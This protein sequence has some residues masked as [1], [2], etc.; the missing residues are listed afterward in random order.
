MSVS[1]TG[2][3]RMS[4]T[5]L[6]EAIRSKQVSSQ[7]VIGAHLRRIEEVNPS[8]NA[9]TVVL[10]EQ[11]LEA[12]KAADRAVAGGGDLPPLHGVPFTVKEDIDL[13]GT[14]TTFGAKALRAAFEV[15][16]E[17]SWRDPWT[18]PA[19]LRGPEPAKPIRVAVATD[20]A[21]QGTADQVREGV[22]QAARALDD[23]GYA[24]DEVEPPSIAEAA[25]T[26]VDMLTPDWHLWWRFM[27]ASAA[28]DVRRFMSAL[29]EVVGEPDPMTTVQRFMIRQSLLRAWASS[30][31]R[32]R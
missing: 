7:E 16:A 29:L 30:R 22:Q 13:V 24:V 23:A 15:V 20:P 9:V 32:T 21:G 10:G 27:S 2:L 31:R 5:D 12:A 1:A 25:K 4:A 3:W 11:A 26:A 6:A 19:P 17:P 18:V 28:A 8:V 14:P